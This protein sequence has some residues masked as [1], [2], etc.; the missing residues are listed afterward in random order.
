MQD[1]QFVHLF[2]YGLLLAGEREHDLLSDSAFLG[3]RRT[4]PA[5]TL[6][7][8]TVYPA[9]LNSGHTAV[10]GELYLVSKA[11][12]YTLDVRHECPVLFERIEIT[13]EDGTV[14]ETYVMRED[15]VRGKRR[16]GQ[17]SWRDRF[18]PRPRSGPENPFALL[19]RQR[20]GRR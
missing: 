11:V 10:V 5:F 9:L 17:G 18:A 15:Q 19:A 16:L 4:Q 2:V 12:R 6:V 13:L 8:L 1:A 7:D 3:Q 14:A 20:F